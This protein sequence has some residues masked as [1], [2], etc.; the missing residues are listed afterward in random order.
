MKQTLKVGKL[1]IPVDNP[2]KVLYPAARFTKAA[3][4]AYYVGVSR[5]ILPHLKNRPVALKMILAGGH[6]SR[7]TLARFR[8]EAEAVAS[9]QHGN[10]VQVYEIGDC[11]GLP[12]FSLEYCAG[13]S[14]ADRLN[15]SH[16]AISQD[17]E[18]L[19]GLVGDMQEGGARK[20]SKGAAQGVLDAAGSKL[21]D[22]A[23]NGDH[24]PARSRRGKED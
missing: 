4:V 3:V 6:A 10:I 16:Q 22:F 7:T 2:D 23:E 24:E 15:G 19:P 5:F 13:G 1:S 11:D 8:A 9:L 17:K 12:F 21:R 18:G 14:L 20:K